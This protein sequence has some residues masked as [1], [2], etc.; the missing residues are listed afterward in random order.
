MQK[1]RGGTVNNWVA[2]LLLAALAASA[3]YNL[4]W[5]K[6]HTITIRFGNEITNPSTRHAGAFP[7]NA[8][9]CSGPGVVCYVEI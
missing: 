3:S 1:Q 8:Y 6:H 5:L 4:Y 2:I 9:S 7:R